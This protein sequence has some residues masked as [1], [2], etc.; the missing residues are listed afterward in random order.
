M[1]REAIA[2]RFPQQFRPQWNRPE[3]AGYRSKPCDLQARPARARVAARSLQRA[4]RSGSELGSC[5][6]EPG[7]GFGLFVCLAN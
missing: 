1:Q 3:R 2:A 4:N 5:G 7:S 6:Q